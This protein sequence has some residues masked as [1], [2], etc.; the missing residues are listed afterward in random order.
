MDI[1]DIPDLD[2]GQHAVDGKLI[3]VLA[4]AAGDIVLM[5]AGGVLL[6]QHGNMVVGAVHGR[7][8][9]VG[10]AGI[11][12]DVLLIDMLLMQ[13]GRDKR[14]VGCQHKAAH[15]GENRHIAHT[16]G[17]QNFLKLFADTLADGCNVVAALVGAVGDAHTARQIDE[18]DLGAGALM[19]ADSQLKQDTGQL[20]VIVI[21]DG[22]AGQEGVNT[23][24]LG[25]GS[26]QLGVCLGHLVLAHAVLGI[27]GVVHD[28]VAQLK[29]TARIVAAAYGLGYTGNLLKKFDMGQIIQIDVRA[30]VVGLLHILRRGIVGGKHNVTAPEAAG[31]AHQQLRIAGAVDAAALLLQDLEQIGVRRGLYGEIFFKALVPAE[32]SVDP[33]GI[34]PDTLFVIEVERGGNIGGDFFRLCKRD[35]RHFLRH[36]T[37]S[38]PS[39]YFQRCF[40]Y[41][42][43][44]DRQQ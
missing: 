44:A 11:H 25:T 19:Q 12:A 22:V 20:G 15:L 17:D 4:Q 10:G 32:R 23:E 7:A 27:T 36:G 26:H 38:F 31:L 39:I 37:L 41:I 40:Y 5:V 28:T 1:N 13:H 8:H 16:G 3:I 18:L 21:G 43:F 9:Q 42:R 14:T 2:L 35:K 30:E 34:F 6:A 29:H 24:L 33:A